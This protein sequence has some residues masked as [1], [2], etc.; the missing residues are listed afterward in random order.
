M[1]PGK[2]LSRVKISRLA[3]GRF[4]DHNDVVTVEEPLEIR[5]E[6]T[7]N[8]V[9]ETSAVS[10]TMRTPGNDFELAAG[11]LYGEG[12]LRGRED[13]AEI[14][15]CQSDE[16]Q[17]YNIVVVKLRSGTLFDPAT[18]SRNFYMSSSCGVCGKASLEAVE[19]RGC[20][21]IPD[22]GLSVDRAI[23]SGLPEKLRAQQDLFDR[24][25]GIHA[26]GRFDE[27]GELVSVREDVGRHN[28]V[29]KVVGE[30]FLAGELPLGRTVL[31]VSGRTSFEIMQKALA[32]GI[33]L[34]V[35]VGAPSSLA[36]DL[37]RRFNMS[38]LGFT[39]SDGFNVYAGAER[40]AT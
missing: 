4:V 34:V 37:A 6:F 39:R 26:A 28:A 10:V 27:M 19:V 15:Y 18:L 24:T 1:S 38:L 31:A 29:D 22:E 32:A 12:L 21:Q 17:T 20:E 14:S 7:K 8:G 30:A 40:I 3:D 25:G 23:L 13:V 2:G 5:V 35:A 16:P 9:R 33:P 11:F 36:V